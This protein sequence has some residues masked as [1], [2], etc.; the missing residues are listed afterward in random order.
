[1]TI[2]TALLAL[3]LGLL[4]L[5]AFELRAIRRRLEGRAGA[6][7]NGLES[8]EAPVA[9]QTIN[10]NLAPLP[11]SAPGIPQI[12]VPVPGGPGAP[13]SPPPPAAAE[14]PS[15]EEPEAARR[16]REREQ[17]LARERREAQSQK[18]AQVSA[19]QSGLMA[20]KCPSCGA[21]NSSYRDACFNCG[22]SL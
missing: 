22:S 4:I 13:G 9:G 1:M 10:V 17:L 5:I 16:A 18:S 14:A 20:V 12:L 3:V 19:T 6:A 7:R 15:E 11:A 2:T 21:E 8:R